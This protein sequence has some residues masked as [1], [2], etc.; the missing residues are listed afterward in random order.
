[1]DN[2]SSGTKQGDDPVM[3]FSTNNQIVVE[4]VRNAM[5]SEGIPSLLKSPT[6]SYL[7]GMLPISQFYFDFQLFV[8]SEDSQRA[9]EIVETIVP[10]E[11]A[12]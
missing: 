4:M 8:T 6:G 10:A 7:R 9:S 1:M 3:I 5:E 11:E 2:N 12:L